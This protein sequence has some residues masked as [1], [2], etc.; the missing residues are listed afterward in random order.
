MKIKIPDNLQKL[1]YMLEDKK[2]DLNSLLDELGS[3]PDD[4][5]KLCHDYYD[6]KI[7]V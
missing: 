5:I 3:N 7:I 6:G 1:K 4:Y 2:T